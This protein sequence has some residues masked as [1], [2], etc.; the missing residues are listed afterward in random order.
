MTEMI[1]GGCKE[2][3]APLSAY[4]LNLLFFASWC[5]IAS[6]YGRHGGPV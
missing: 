6:E 1:Q 4:F 5:S 2:A 3:N